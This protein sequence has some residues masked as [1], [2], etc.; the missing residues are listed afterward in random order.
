MIPIYDPFDRLRVVLSRPKDDPFGKLRSSTPRLRRSSRGLSPE[1]LE[2]V[3]LS[4]PK[5]E[6]MRMILI[7]T[8][9]RIPFVSLVKLVY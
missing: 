6:F 9:I 8:N 7:N 5:D 3:V 1:G 4:R 2:E